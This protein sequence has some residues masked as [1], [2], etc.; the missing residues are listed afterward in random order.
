VG[1]FGLSIHPFLSVDVVDPNLVDPVRRIP[2]VGLDSVRPAVELA[3]P[4]AHPSFWVLCP[5]S[6]S[7]TETDVL[8]RGFIDE[9]HVDFG[10]RTDHSAVDVGLGLVEPQAEAGGALTSPI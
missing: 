8:W 5:V 1:D 2:F 10:L 4:D 9:P 6:A 7:V 3:E